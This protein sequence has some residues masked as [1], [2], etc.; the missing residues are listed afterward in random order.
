[1]THILHSIIQS[2]DYL[3]FIVNYK[4]ELAHLATNA[5]L[6]WKY[7]REIIKTIAFVKRTRGNG[8]IL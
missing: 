3:K 5:R 7:S 2:C 6:H 8:A 1:M 4:V